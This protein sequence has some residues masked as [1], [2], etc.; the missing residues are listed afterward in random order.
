[1]L[2]LTVFDEFMVEKNISSENG[3]SLLEV[4]IAIFVVSIGLLGAAGMYTRAIAF[5]LDTERRQV[6]AMLAGEMLEIMRSDVVRIIG[7]DGAPRTDLGGYAKA[8]GV[9]LAPSTDEACANVLPDSATE[10][11]NCWAGRAKG[12]IPDLTDELINN[13]F[14]ISQSAGIVSIQVAWPVKAGEC[15]DGSNNNYCIYKLQSRL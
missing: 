5:S 8:S 9:T 3:F 13:Q 7:R 1:M 4:L 10:R 11:L 14:T 6:A 2:R 15:L 12:L